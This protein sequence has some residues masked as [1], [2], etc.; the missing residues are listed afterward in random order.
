MGRRDPCPHSGLMSGSMP[1][2]CVVGRPHALYSLRSHRPS[3]V[4]Q[5][6]SF[7]LPSRPTMTVRTPRPRSQ[8]LALRLRRVSVLDTEAHT[9]NLPIYPTSWDPMPLALDISTDTMWGAKRGIQKTHQ[10]IQQGKSRTSGTG[11]IMRW[12]SGKVP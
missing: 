1:A 4:Y 6:L 11:W 12:V 5:K 9:A 3:S 2:T 8:T 7:T 10:S